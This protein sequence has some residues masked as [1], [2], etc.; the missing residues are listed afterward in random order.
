MH[1]DFAHHG[2]LIHA[3]L[4]QDRDPQFLRGRAGDRDAMLWIDCH[5]VSLPQTL[6]ASS[7]HPAAVLTRTPP[8]H[9]IM[10][11]QSLPVA[12]FGLVEP[13]AVRERV[14]SKP[15][16]LLLDDRE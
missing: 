13:F 15:F 9:P 14:A 7:E 8:S 4:L 1:P 3:Q 6:L 12:R 2:G 11:Q 16:A 5:V 10:L